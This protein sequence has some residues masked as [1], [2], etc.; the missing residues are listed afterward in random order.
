MVTE[1]LFE[2]RFHTASELARLGA[3]VRV[4]GH[5]ALLRGRER[6]SAAPV[7]GSDIRAVAALV[8]AGLV[9]DGVTTV[10]GIRHVDRGYPDFDVELRALGA[11]VDREH[12]R[13]ADFAR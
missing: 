12:G 13:R 7:V 9:A 10:E 1:N 3:D 11:D 5:H 4:D 8:L 6:L 2:A